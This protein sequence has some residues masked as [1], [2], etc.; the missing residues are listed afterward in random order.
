[1]RPG[2][3]MVVV[4]A[5]PTGPSQV[6]IGGILSSP[7]GPPAPCPRWGPLSQLMVPQG[8]YLSVSGWTVSSPS[9]DAEEPSASGRGLE[10]LESP[11]SYG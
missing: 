9:F 5:G 10:G 7:S 8:G 1:M 11:S 6:D 2:P 4:G 3:V